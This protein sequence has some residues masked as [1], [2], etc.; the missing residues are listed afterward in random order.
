MKTKSRVCTACLS[1]IGIGTLLCG[2]YAGSAYAAPPEKSI[3]VPA[4]TGT[5]TGSKA[6]ARE[7]DT[8]I[9]PGTT[10]EVTAPRES[11]T[12]E[13]SGK[14]STATPALQGGGTPATAAATGA[15]PRAQRLLYRGCVTDGFEFTVQGNA[16]DAGMLTCATTCPGLRVTNRALK[17]SAEQMLCRLNG[18]FR[19]NRTCAIGARDT[20]RWLIR[21][22]VRTCGAAGAESRAAASPAPTP[23]VAPPTAALR[24]DTPAAPSGFAAPSATL[25]R[26]AA[27]TPG[28]SVRIHDTQPKPAVVGRSV[29]I[30]GQGFG[31]R[32][33]VQLEIGGQRLALTTS[34]WSDTEIA[35]L[36]PRH[37]G[38]TVGETEKEGRLWVHADLG[39]ATGTLQVGP[40]AALMTPRITRLSSENLRPAQRLTIEGNHFLSEARGLVQISCPSLRRVFV[41]EILDWNDTTIGTR[42]TT[43]TSTALSS[44]PCELLVQ[45]HRGLRATRPVTLSASLQQRELTLHVDVRREIRGHAPGRMGIFEL[46]TDDL[47]N[48]WVVRD[49]RIE[50]TRDGHW[51]GVDWRWLSRPTPGSSATSARVHLSTRTPGE[52]GSY[53]SEMRYIVEI[54]GPEG[55]PYR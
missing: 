55:L 42:F 16:L 40:D 21:R 17:R 35:A 29:I 27:S 33:R 19:P 44:V 37:L 38:A 23:A 41:G 30:S 51:Q 12:Q 45:N 24:K 26:Q 46:S 49:S 10:H 8:S 22:P 50:L 15:K 18:Q 54:K 13:A 28:A 53:P 9:S 43:P 14:R 36:V 1:I 7:A 6:P 20:D 5:I 25:G 11:N 3:S 39:G 34:R 48:G 47:I 31:H 4:Q 32:G 2:F 52:P